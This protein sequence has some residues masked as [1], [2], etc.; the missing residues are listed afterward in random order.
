MKTAVLALALLVSGA[1]AQVAF[2]GLPLG[3]ERQQLLSAFPSLQC[4]KAPAQFRVGEE[5]CMEGVCSTPAC[6]DSSKALATYAGMPSWDTAFSLVSGRVEFFTAHIHK[7]SYDSVRDALR[8]VYGRGQ[9]STRAAQT[10]GGARLQSR[11]W[12][13]KASDGATITL[14]EMGNTLDEGSVVAESAA[15]KQWRGQPKDAKKNAGDI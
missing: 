10:I 15:F 13:A 7:T 3:A 11:V 9:E 2:K 6:K 14:F 1:H 8:E 5:D 12:D 4:M